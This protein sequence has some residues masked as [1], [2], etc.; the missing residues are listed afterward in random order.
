MKLRLLALGAFIMCLT[1][2]F[3]MTE[4][5]NIK[6]DGTGTYEMKMDMS[7]AFGMLAMLKQGAKEDSK[8]PEKLD[9][10]IYYKSFVDTVST[11]TAEEK[12]AFQNGYAKIHMNEEEGDMYVNM[13]FPFADGKQLSVIQKALS[14]SGNGSVMD[15]VGNAVKSG[16]GAPAG[17]DPMSGGMTAGAK[18]DNKQ[19]LP[20]SDFTYTLG[21]NNFTRTVKAST[22][23]TATPAKEDEMPEQFK[24]MMKINY[25]TIINLPRPAKNLS[26][27]ATLSADK[28]QVKFTKSMGIDD[29][30]TPA[31][32]D[33][34]I[35]Y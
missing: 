29:K 27:K 4:T 2:C 33:F 32:F 17:A 21:I 1:G 5:F 22:S 14:K 24:E 18:Q 30:H 10:I 7:R 9:S 35:D 28:K 34:S 8:M 26:G 16:L 25:T 19:G 23:T 12:A 31:D 3:D 15:A 6:E 11:L 13:Y 20:M